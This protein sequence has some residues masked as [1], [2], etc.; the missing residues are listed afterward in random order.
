MTEDSYSI[1]DYSKEELYKIFLNEFTV[2]Q[3]IKSNYRIQY[4]SSYLSILNCKKIIIENEYIDKDY[5]LDYQDFY[6][7]C[8]RKYS[9]FCKRAHYFSCPITNK[10]INDIIENGKGLELI[11]KKLQDSYLGFTIIKPLP[12]KVVGKTCIKYFTDS[13]ER[14]FLATRDDYKANLFGIDLKVKSLAF[15]EQD[16]IMGACATVS[17]WCAFHKTAEL[18]GH[19]IMSPGEITRSATKHH[20]SGNREIPSEGLTIEQILDGIQ[21]TGLT[22]EV[23]KIENDEK[24]NM[25]DKEV[26]LGTIY[27]YL[28]LG[29]PIIL[30]VVLKDG[31]RHAVTITGY[32]TNEENIGNVGKPNL[33]A[34]NIN[35]LY[36]HD[37]NIGPFSRVFIENKEYPKFLF[38]LEEEKSSEQ[39]ITRT[40]EAHK[41]MDKLVQFRTGVK[42]K[43]EYPDSTTKEFTPYIM[44]IPLYH[45]IRINFKKIYS[46]INKINGIFKCAFIDPLVYWDIF[47]TTSNSLKKEIL[48]NK[49]I[50]KDIRKD[51]LTSS[52][53][54]Y[55][56]RCKAISNNNIMM[57]IISDSTDINANNSFLYILGSDNSRNALKNDFKQ[58]L[59][60]S[61]GKEGLIGIAGHRFMVLFE[62]YLNV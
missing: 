45:K 35:R 28:N 52:L 61:N 6:V 3:N 42:L 22:Y 43:F 41:F 30:G 53:P 13:E 31:Q 15:Q 38:K 34:Y 36:V 4:L 55:I 2:D 58:V 12:E 9:K 14:I 62:K 46:E 5:L 26:L 33:V 8:Y 57:E 60:D 27:A 32:R 47:L 59:A 10:E 7:R 40:F 50:S 19:S 37:D 21:Q 49:E 16:T 1:I 17:L 20:L 44:V 23:T 11:Q 25:G 29:I 39:K 24:T 56:W 48:T 18:F 54:R 51:I